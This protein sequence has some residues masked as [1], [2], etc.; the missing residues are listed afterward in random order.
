MIRSLNYHLYLFLHFLE[1][2][3]M[4]SLIKKISLIKYLSSSSSSLS[5]SFSEA[6]LRFTL[7]KISTFVTW[8]FVIS[9]ISKALLVTLALIILYSIKIAHLSVP[10]LVPSLGQ[11]TSQMEYHSPRRLQIQRLSLFHFCKISAGSL[12]RPRLF[13][14]LNN[15]II[16]NY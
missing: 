12:I 15:K 6:I 8:D 4:N 7:F 10:F 16:Y 5:E 9:G 13:I 1:R 2:K 11:R 3:C 14:I